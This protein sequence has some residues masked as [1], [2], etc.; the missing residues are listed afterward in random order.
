LEKLTSLL[1]PALM[2]VMLVRWLLLPMKAAGALAIRSGCGLLCLWLLNTLTPFTG[3]T[4]PINAVT[5][6]TAGTLGIPGVG[7]VALLAVL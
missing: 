2:A 4:L 7:I 3:I 1:I 6:L 5:V